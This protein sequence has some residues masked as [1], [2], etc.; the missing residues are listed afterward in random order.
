[1][2]I[3]R[4][5]A[6]FLLAFGI[7]LYV[8]FFLLRDGDRI[9]IGSVVVVYSEGGGAPPPSSASPDAEATRIELRIERHDGRVEVR[10]TD[11]GCGGAT[12]RV[13]SGLADRVAALGG[14]LQVLSPPGHGTVV[15]AAL[16]CAS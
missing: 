10:V 13:G 16:P 14:S 3:G 12:L 5:A 9:G 2:S 7:A 6:A 11:D 4:N 15:R 8:T 1:M